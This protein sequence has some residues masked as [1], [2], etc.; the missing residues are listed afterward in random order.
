MRGEYIIFFLCVCA[1]G[2]RTRGGGGAGEERGE[3][4]CEGEGGGG[5]SAGGGGFG[6]FCWRG[7]GAVEV[8]V[9]FGE[10]GGHGFVLFF[11]GA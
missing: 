10:V 7:G 8:R 6:A 4:G 3:G 11:R 9:C 5:G 2:A 1:A